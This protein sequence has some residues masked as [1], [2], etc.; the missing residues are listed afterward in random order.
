MFAFVGIMAQE[1]SDDPVEEDVTTSTPTA[2][3]DR[4]T[5]DRGTIE[6]R[7]EEIKMRR[8]AVVDTARD[9]VIKGRCIAAQAKVKSY[10]A[11]VLTGQTRRS[12]AYENISEKLSSIV[13]RLDGLNVDTAEAS[14]LISTF[15]VMWMGLVD[16]IADYKLTL[17]DLVEMDCVE[18]TEGF[19][20]A[21]E[22]ARSLGATLKTAASDVHSF[23]KNEVKTALRVLIGEL[24]T[25][26]TDEGGV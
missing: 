12:V 20:A 25:D 15:D 10:A 16:D 22:E 13:S 4:L 17:D 3:T 19:Q 23:L 11:N 6:E 24:Q 2:V 8:Q 26:D 14:D 1:G 21:L 5:V 7:I 18:D 9:R